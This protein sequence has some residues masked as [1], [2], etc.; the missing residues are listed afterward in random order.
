MSEVIKGIFFHPFLMEQ[1]EDADEYLATPSDL[2]LKIDY[3]E[4]TTENNCTYAT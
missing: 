2:I 4:S 1:D 3:T